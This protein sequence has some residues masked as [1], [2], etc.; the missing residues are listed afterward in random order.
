M[1]EVDS[2]PSLNLENILST[3]YKGN[4][5]SFFPR[6]KNSTQNNLPPKVGTGWVPYQE[7]WQAHRALRLRVYSESASSVTHDTAE[8]ELAAKPCPN[9]MSLAC[10]IEFSTHF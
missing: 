2:F 5:M 4:L 3:S 8:A 1:G 9:Q 7:N 10:T 6:L